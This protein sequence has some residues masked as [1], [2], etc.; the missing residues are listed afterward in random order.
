M[1]PTISDL[2]RDLFGIHLPLPVQTFGFML[3]VSFLAAAYTLQLELKRKERQGLL[4]V[5]TVRR[6][7]G[8][9]ATFTELLWSFLMGF[10]I[11]Y[12][13]VYAL[14]NYSLFVEDTQSFILSLKG[15]AVGGLLLGTLMAY[16]NYREK[17]KQRL[18]S[19]KVIT[20]EIHPYQMVS[21]F[22]M[23]AAVSGIIGAKLFHNLENFDDL[24]ADPV[25]A[26]LS[27]SGLTMYGGLIVGSISVCWYAYRHGVPPLLLADATAPG[28]MLAYGTGRLGCQ[29][30][31]DGDWGVVNL[32]SKPVFLSWLPDWAWSYHY[33]NNVI[34]EGILI[35]GC[36]GRHCMMLPEP[37]FPTPLYE[38]TACILLFAV[39]WMLRK[40]LADAG[41][42]F[43][44]Y[45]LL[46]GVE[47]IVIE[48]IRV[49]NRFQLFG[50]N[51]TQAEVIA[52]LLIIA[53]G[54]GLWY[55]NNRPFKS[56]SLHSHG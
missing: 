12:K 27:F 54:V 52:S 15:N 3:A 10:I 48:Q 9:P 31:G 50:L 13:G 53:G 41:A 14:S 35:P 37:V 49:N 17:E 8:E 16:W 33:P 26:L 43:S 22:T 30:S 25:G 40:R 47:R 20:E 55:F 39:L 18:P 23:V 46:N 6:T 1:Y 32:E 38:A 42:M 56:K 2:I 34:N 21:S 44:L 28:L 24:V 45:L 51:V 29:L 19:P 4:N 36:D 5:L 7:V 11:G